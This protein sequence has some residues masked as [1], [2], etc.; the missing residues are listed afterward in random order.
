MKK[1]KPLEP[2]NSDN[3]KAKLNSTQVFWLLI[4]SVILAAIYAYVNIM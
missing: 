1:E 2:F 3:K 4:F